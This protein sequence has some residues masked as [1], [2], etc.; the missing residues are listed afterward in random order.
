MC[1]TM[2]NIDYDGEKAKTC[3]HLG[4]KIYGFKNI[5]WSKA[6]GTKCKL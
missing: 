1:S 2:I 4:P 5:L 6:Y 3:R